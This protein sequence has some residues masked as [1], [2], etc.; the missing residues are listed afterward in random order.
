MEKTKN[1]VEPKKNDKYIYCEDCI[2][3]TREEKDEENRKYPVLSKLPLY[4]YP[5]TGKAVLVGYV[6]K[7][8]NCQKNYEFYWVKEPNK[9]S[10]QN[11][12]DMLKKA[13]EGKYTKGLTEA[14]LCA[15]KLFEV[16]EDDTDFASYANRFN[17]LLKQYF[18]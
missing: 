7:C 4:V 12:R 11:I 5:P 17:N 9:Y 6:S 16:R 15:P 13:N 3:K 2:A 14:E 1:T 10:S 8:L 18:R